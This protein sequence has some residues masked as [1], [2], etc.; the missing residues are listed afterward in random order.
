MSRLSKWWAT[1]LLVRLSAQTFSAT[2]SPTGYGSGPRRRF[3]EHVE[4]LLNGGRAVLLDHPNLESQL[5]GLV[6]RATTKVDHPVGE[7][8]DLATAASGALG[9]VVNECGGYEP[10]HH[11]G[12][13][14]VL[15]QYGI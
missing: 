4:P 6:W 3:Y 2:A 9:S 10:N 7:H 11:G 1:L 8:D 12:R 5:L 15:I 13:A 14:Q